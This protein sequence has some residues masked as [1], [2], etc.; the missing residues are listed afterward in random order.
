MMPSG[1]PC[2]QRCRNAALAART[3]PHRACLQNPVIPCVC[4]GHAAHRVSPVLR[5]PHSQGRGRLTAPVHTIHV[6]RSHIQQA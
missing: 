6:L 2:F 5:V 1:M 3:L 4:V